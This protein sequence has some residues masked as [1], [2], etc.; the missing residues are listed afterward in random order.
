MLEVVDVCSGYLDIPSLLCLLC[1]SSEYR[2]IVSDFTI[3]QE[4]LRKA[5]FKRLC[6]AHCTSSFSIVNAL[7]TIREHVKAARACELCWKKRAPPIRLQNNS[8]SALC[9]SCEG[10]MLCTRKDINNILNTYT[11]RP[12]LRTLFSQLVVAKRRHTRQHLYWKCQVK[13]I[14]RAL[15]DRY[16]YLL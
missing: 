14:C 9:V 11:C 13:H 6:N 7:P 16:P 15:T 2:Q 10:G 12:K 1:V 5:G 3:W 4:I 8:V